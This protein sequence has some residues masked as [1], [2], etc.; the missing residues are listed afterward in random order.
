MG[1]VKIA[2]LG[3]AAELLVSCSLGYVANARRQR[4]KIGSSAAPVSPGR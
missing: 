3:R 4:L 1:R 2:K